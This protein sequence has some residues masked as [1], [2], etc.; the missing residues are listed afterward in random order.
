MITGWGVCVFFLSVQRITFAVGCSRSC[1][2]PGGSA[3]GLLDPNAIDD[4]D[5]ISLGSTTTLCQNLRSS[6]SGG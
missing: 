4:P 1:F 3:V 2:Q 5:S 6:E